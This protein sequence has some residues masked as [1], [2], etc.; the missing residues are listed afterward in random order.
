MQ[1]KNE[2]YDTDRETTPLVRDSYVGL[3]GPR[4]I[5]DEYTHQRHQKFTGWFVDKQKCIE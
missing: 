5:D 1:K 4:Q 2:G 3:R